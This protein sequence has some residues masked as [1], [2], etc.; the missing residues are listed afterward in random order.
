VIYGESEMITTF[1]DLIKFLEANSDTENIGVGMTT[2]DFST[3]HF[4]RKLKESEEESL[5]QLA[6]K[7]AI[8]K[9]LDVDEQSLTFEMDQLVYLGEGQYNMKRLTSFLKEINGVVEIEAFS[10]GSEFRLRRLQQ[11]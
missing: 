4:A 6:R 10:T 1:D 11:R 5:K 9:E 2:F 8:D 3:I 7:Y